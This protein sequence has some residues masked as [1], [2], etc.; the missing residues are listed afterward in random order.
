M[1]VEFISQVAFFLQWVTEARKWPSN[2]NAQCQLFIKIQSSFRVINSQI[3]RFCELF[4]KSSEK[5]ARVRR[6]QQRNNNNSEKG[7]SSCRP[8][9]GKGMCCQGTA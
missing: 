3:D 2:N 1:E 9:D 5:K 6:L 8:S 4:L 7:N